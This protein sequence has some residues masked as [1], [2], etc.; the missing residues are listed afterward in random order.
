M[1]DY[2]GVKCPV[3]G[4]P[5]QPEDDVVVCPECGAP[6]H[7]AC[8]EKEGKC[9][10]DDLHAQGKE[11][12][13]PEPPKAPDP[14]AEIKDRECPVCGTLNGHSALFCNRCGASL[15]GQPQPHQNQASPYSGQQPRGA[16]YGGV[17]PPF[18][19]D[20]MGGVSPAEELDQG[21]T[22]GDASKVVKQN[23]AY[24]MTVFR[25]MKQTRRNKFSVCAFFFSGPWMLYRKMYKG[26]AIVTLLLFGLY[27]AFQFLLAFVS[28]P[29][30]L[31]AVEALGLDQTAALAYGT[32]EFAQVVQYVSLTPELYLAIVCPWFCAV[33][34]LAVMIVT[35]VK[36]NK[37]YMNHCVRT[38]R[39][40]KA[41]RV[42]DD[43]TMTL[44]A[45]GGVNVA[46]AVCM[47]VCY[48][49]LVNVVPLLL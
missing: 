29:A 26:G 36:G 47:F 8:Y 43:P 23:T 18:A 9:V 3:C 14:A 19:F 24:Y 31:Q 33:P 17:V 21:V 39:M 27:L 10:F 15:T 41:N 35:G 48:F 34:L 22:F 5:F 28:V 44:D 45:R 32:Q 42:E 7:R 16:Y 38:V 4:V 12:Q 37:W 11:W 2:T 1:L 20:P 46:V 25:Y 13:P 40:V 30:F 49:L 6:Y